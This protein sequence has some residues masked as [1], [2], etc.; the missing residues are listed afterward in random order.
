VR[1][2]DLIRAIAREAKRQGVAWAIAREGAN[3]TI[4]TLGRLRLPIPRH[5]EIGERLARAIL[6]ETEAELGRRW[7]Q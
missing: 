7:W 2:A 5:V 1:R 6:D 3:H 4:F